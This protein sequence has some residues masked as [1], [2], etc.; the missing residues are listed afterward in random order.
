VDGEDRQTSRERE[1]Q[2]AYLHL[3]PWYSPTGSYVQIHSP[4][5]AV[6]C[7]STLALSVSYTTRT[8]LP[9]NPFS[10]VYQVMSIKVHRYKCVQLQPHQISHKILDVIAVAD[11]VEAGRASCPAPRSL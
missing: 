5:G 2:N 4:D 10:Y 7:R 11:F 6:A 3:K 1:R 9:A 8:L